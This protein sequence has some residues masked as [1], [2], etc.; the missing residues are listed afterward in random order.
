MKS[1]LLFL[2]ALPL[3]GLFPPKL[4]ITHLTGDFYIYTTYG[5]VGGQ[6]YPSNS[7]YLITS[8]GAV[9]FDP[10]WDSTQ[11]Q[12]LL[13]SIYT[14]HHAKVICCLSTHFHEDRTAGLTFLQKQGIPTWSTVQTRELCRQRQED[15]AEYVFTGDTTFT[16]G[17]YTFRTFYPGAGHT[18]DNIVIWFD[19]D[20][21]LYGGCFVKSTEAPDLGNL[22]DADPAAWPASVRRTMKAFPRPAYVIP[23][24][25]GWSDKESLQHTLKL[26]EQYQQTQK[27]SS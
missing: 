8:Q 7:M 12:P 15:Q 18:R 20:K 27:K 13:D 19:R 25:L 10:P 5:Q 11:F 1:L 2:L 14:R 9:L 24:H 16:F 4:T 6:S 22:S 26:L 23:G 3:V 21:V 17:N